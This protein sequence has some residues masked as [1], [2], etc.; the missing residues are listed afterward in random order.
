MTI[1]ANIFKPSRAKLASMQKS[2]SHGNIFECH[3]ISICVTQTSTI[4]TLKDT[5]KARSLKINVD[6]NNPKETGIPQM[7]FYSSSQ[8]NHGQRFQAVPP[9]RTIHFSKLKTELT[10]TELPCGK[11]K[12]GLRYWTWLPG[13]SPHHISAQ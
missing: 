10:M 8:I 9:D 6:L 13:V 4:V 7:L 11:L 1:C 12:E 3:S 5:P 2:N